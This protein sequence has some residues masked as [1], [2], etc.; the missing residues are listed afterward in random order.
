MVRRKVT[1]VS[2]PIVQ[3]GAPPVSSPKASASRRRTATGRKAGRPKGALSKAKRALL[4]AQKAAGLE[5]LSPLAFM[6]QVV[7]TPSYDVGLRLDAARY[8]APYVHR[9]QP[10]EIIGSGTF[11]QSASPAEIA[12]AIKDQL[13]ALGALTL[14]APPDLHGDS[15]SLADHG[16]GSAAG[17]PGGS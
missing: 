10:T 6:L 3:A 7:R 4:E 11:G 13:D 2:Q 12:I 15:E 9:K 16:S 5:D 17:S 1:G 14:P 8:A